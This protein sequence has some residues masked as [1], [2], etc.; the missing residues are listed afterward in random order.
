MKKFTYLFVVFLTIGVLFVNRDKYSEFFQSLNPCDRPITY[1]VDFVDKRFNLTQAQF[2]ADVKEAASIWNSKRGKDVFVYDEQGKVSVNLIFDSR[3][4][5]SNQI[6]S[7]DNQLDKQKGQ[8]DAETRAYKNQVEDFKK[9]L[10]VHNEL[11]QSWNNQGGAPPDEFEKLAREQQDLQSEANKLN[12]K[13]GSLNLSSENYNLQ[14]GKLNSAIEDFNTD[15]SKKPEE[16]IFMGD[17]MRIEIYF[18]NNK[19]ELVHTLAHELG[20]SLGVNH[21]NNPKSIM[22]PYTTKTVLLS[23]ADVESL[24]SV[25][26]EISVFEAFSGWIDA[27]RSQW[28]SN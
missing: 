5:E 28:K 2:L 12:E 13:A 9:R 26:R 14:V 23:A 7:L 6:N 25:C 11:V 19:Q 15:L 1:R 17:K 24:D 27:L 22:Y 16:G 8:L 20:H 3:Q 4:Q 18:N 10:E 21:N